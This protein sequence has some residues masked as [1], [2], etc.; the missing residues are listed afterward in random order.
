[1]TSP[2][3]SRHSSPRGPSPNLSLQFDRGYA[4][5]DAH[6]HHTPA[7]PKHGIPEG[8]TS[9]LRAFV[10]RFS[11]PREYDPF[12]ARREA[13]LTQQRARGIDRTSSAPMVVGLGRW[14]P[15][16]CGFNLDRFTGCPFIPGSSVKGLLRDAAGLVA[17]GELADA[18]GSSEFWRQRVDL[19]FGRET[20]N[21]GEAADQAG[22]VRFFDA[23]P[24]R[25]PKLELDVMTPHY[26]KYYSGRNAEAGDWEDPIPVHFLRVAA[27]TTIRFWFGPRR[28]TPLD[29]DT[30]RYIE[31]LLKLALDWVGI[32]GKTS[33]GY[34]WFDDF[35]PSGK[36]GVP[37]STPKP[38][39]GLE[40]KRLEWAGAVLELDRG[41]GTLHAHHGGLK[42][43]A[44]PQSVR[45]VITADMLA[46]VRNSRRPVT[47][48]VIVIEIGNDRRIVEVRP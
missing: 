3:P 25:W 31:A 27:N 36:A 10:E 33:S 34:G 24:V 13:A 11:D 46:Q 35:A 21:G 14:N 44:K 20:E 26:G 30:V 22:T 23:Y 17:K 5:Y 18:P 32:G 1:M 6:W 15:T 9:F 48:T 39:S 4:G 2:L 40:E 38:G 12:T 8:R 29:A 7:D 47:A 45:N 42:A 28:R 19:V 41:S 37:G 16:E 43:Y